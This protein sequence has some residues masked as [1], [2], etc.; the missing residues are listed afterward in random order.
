LKLEEVE[1]WRNWRCQ[2]VEDIWSRRYMKS[3]WRKRRL[4]K[5]KI[6]EV[7]EL[8]KSK[9]EKVEDWRSRKLKEVEDLKFGDSTRV[10]NSNWV[11]GATDMDMPFG[12]PRISIPGPAYYGGRQVQGLEDD[13]EMKKGNSSSYSTRTLV[14]P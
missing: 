2:E 10:C 6:E 13:L 4:K 14:K 11:S 1:V 9:F 3:N 8:K 7:E 5:L 12:Y